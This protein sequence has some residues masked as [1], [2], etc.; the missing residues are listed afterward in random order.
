[1]K[2]SLFI[3]V[4][5]KNTQRMSAG[6]E[7]NRLDTLYSVSKEERTSLRRQTGIVCVDIR[8]FCVTLHEDF[9]CR[10][11]WERSREILFYTDRGWGWCKLLPSCVV[12]PENNHGCIEDFLRAG[13]HA[14]SDSP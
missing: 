11:L 7:S 14:L 12:R 9:R 10:S 5:E 1:M 4:N 3:I 8:Q 13:D 2:T 6:P